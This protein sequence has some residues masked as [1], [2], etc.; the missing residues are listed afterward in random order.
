MF[1]VTNAVLI[2]AY[3]INGLKAVCTIMPILFKGIDVRLPDFLSLL[4]FA[5]CSL[6]ACKMGPDTE[7]GKLLAEIC[8]A[9]DSPG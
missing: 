7:G 1:N 3:N 6:N 5:G 9:L 4:R 2:S 8:S